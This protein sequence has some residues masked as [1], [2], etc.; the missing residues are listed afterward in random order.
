MHLDDAAIRAAGVLAD[1]VLVQDVLGQP[2]AG[3]VRTLAAVFGALVQAGDLV[4]A[5][6][7]AGV[8]FHLHAD[9]RFGQAR[10]QLRG[11]L[12][13]DPACALNLLLVEF[14]QLPLKKITVGIN[15]RNEHGRRSGQNTTAGRGYHV[16]VNHV[17]GAQIPERFHQSIQ[18]LAFDSQSPGKQAEALA[19]AQFAG[20]LAQSRRRIVTKR[21]TQVARDGG[22]GAARSQARQHRGSQRP[23]QALP[24]GARDQDVPVLEPVQV[25][26]DD[27]VF[28]QMGLLGERFVQKRLGFP[29]KV[30][31]EHFDLGAVRSAGG[32][33]ARDD[34]HVLARPCIRTG[35]CDG[36]GV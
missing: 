34:G 28:Q 5:A 4:V 10:R 22:Q 7:P 3:R 32:R 16:E 30:F 12:A 27:A 29:A 2:E 11:L 14:G 15:V 31:F 13:H 35:T 24:G 6:A 20:F 33:R 21:V 26:I 36:H 25:A 19:D 8:A 9:A 1:H 18:L 23:A 17:S